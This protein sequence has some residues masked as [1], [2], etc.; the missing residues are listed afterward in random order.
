MELNDEVVVYTKLP[1]GFYIN[2]PVGRYNPDWAIVFNGDVKHVYF[3]AETKGSLNS[4]QLREIERTKIEC[5]RRHFEAISNSAV[6]YDVVSNYKELY[7][8]VTQ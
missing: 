1:R 5:A 2:T 3:V 6:K 8:L 4:A 7:N